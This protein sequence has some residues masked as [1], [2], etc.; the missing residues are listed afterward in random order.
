MRSPSTSLARVLVVAAAALAARGALAQGAAETF[1]ATASFK[2]PN[3][4]VTSPV[5]IVVN[6]FITDAERASVVAA[7]KKDG[8]AGVRDALAKMPA[9]GHIE[10]GGQEDAVQYAY[11]RSTGDGRL[12]TVISGKPIA[13]LGGNLPG[14]KP[15]AGYD[16]AFALL[17]VP[18]SGMGSGELGPAV[19]VKVGTDGG[20]VTED[21]ASE[22][23]TLS[24]VAKKK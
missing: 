17:I 12:V 5:T 4:I 11:A 23:V 9:V 7:L 3:G 2:G 10:L 6:R 19:K 20:V 14:A 16:L 15:K 22:V 18:A 1:T 13:H 8:T 24:D 21:Y